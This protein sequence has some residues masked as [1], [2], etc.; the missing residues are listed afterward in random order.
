MRK[1]VGALVLLLAVGL[2]AFAE[3]GYKR[4][5]NVRYGYTVKYPKAVFKIDKKFDYGSGITLLSKSGDADMS[6]KAQNNS[7]HTTLKYEYEN[8]QSPDDKF[9]VI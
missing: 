9:K 7:N 8:L 2:G 1:F 4:Y 6:V 5:V 3:E